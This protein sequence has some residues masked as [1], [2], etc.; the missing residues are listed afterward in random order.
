MNV[1]EVNNAGKAFRRR[2]EAKLLRQRFFDFLKPRSSTESFHHALR[3]VSFSV[4]EGEGL[5]ILGSNGAGKSTLLNM[6]AGLA[7]PDSGSLRVNGRVAALLE[8]G[9]G[10][11]PDLTGYENMFLNA[12]FLGFTKA[13]VLERQQ[14]IVDFA[15][16]A[17]FMYEP[18]RTYSQ[19][20]ILRLAFAIAVHV[21]PKILIVDEVLGV[22]DAHF[23]NKCA[24]R[25]AELR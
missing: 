4:A 7:R 18:I 5:A 21:D 17:E 14:A 3:N 12:A 10:F 15:E 20:M 25:I 1:I 16:L 9:A 19:G 22:G 23:Q 11:H 8:L 6:I 13:Q 2:A 24:T